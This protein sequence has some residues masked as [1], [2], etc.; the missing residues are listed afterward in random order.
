LYQPS[1]GIPAGEDSGFH[2][3]AVLEILRTKNPLVSMTPYPTIYPNDT[4][5]YPTFLHSALAI[6]ASIVEY[7][8]SA[9]AD[10]N[11]VI[12][13]VKSFMFAASLVGTA[14]FALLIKT[15]LFALISERLNGNSGIILANS[16]Y[17]LL[18]LTISVVA[19]S[20]FIFSVSPITQTYND[21]G[22]PQLFAMW[23]IFP[24]QMYLLINRHWVSSGFLLA[25]IASSHLFAIFLS[26]SATIPY[27]VFIIIQRVKDFKKGLIKFILA[28]FLFAIPAF[29]FFY[30]PIV[31]G[32]A[33]AVV[34]SEELPSPLAGSWNFA[35][36]IELITP[37]LFYVGIICTVLLFALKY[38]TVGWLPVSATIHFLAFNAAS[39]L[40]A[41]FARDLSVV[42]GIVIGICI[43]YILFAL[44]VYGKK[45]YVEIR[46][47]SLKD[48]QVR[49]S[50]LV[51]VVIICASLV[52]L[53]YF[54]FNDL[55]WSS[56]PLIVK[57]FSSAIGDANKYL[58][59]LTPEGKNNSTLTDDE[60]A[61]IV[62][63]GQNPW[64]KVTTFEKFIVLPVRGIPTAENVTGD[65]RVNS[66]LFRIYS[67]PTIPSTACILKKYDVDFIYLSDALPGRMY[68]SQQIWFYG[69]L[70][71]FQSMFHS[72]FFELER[73]FIGE[74]N[75]NIRIFSVNKDRVNAACNPV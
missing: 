42:F 64:L 30:M 11:L 44:V 25:I 70:R 67:S 48:A 2:T 13:I 3:F 19:F 16:R 51:V 6:V 17:R 32:L 39:E 12:E 75:E 62:L 22:Y 35:R 4:A 40:G 34:Y 63:F 54:N 66:E 60:R 31:P 10:P 15:L 61:V 18:L 52:S 68:D 65:D 5:R 38:K 20:F 74:S 24:Y 26:L 41:R 7:N 69:Q 71:I 56:N 49:S 28:F 59:T 37:G 33:G 47:L 50:K 57:F 1:D 58:L 21:G 46:T 9:L 45:W 14:G 8:Q 36:T 29:I 23:A 43:G 72:P 53:W 55:E 73:E 27:L